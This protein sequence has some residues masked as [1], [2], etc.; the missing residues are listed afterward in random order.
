MLLSDNYK[1]RAEKAKEKRKKKILH[2][3][4]IDYQAN[5]VLGNNTQKG[6]E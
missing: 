3:H 4:L 2:V 1:D 6:E 5:S